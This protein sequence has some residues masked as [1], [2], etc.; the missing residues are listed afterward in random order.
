MAHI[1]V[2]LYN[3]YIKLKKKKKWSSKMNF[4][5]IIKDTDTY[6]YKKCQFH[7]VDFTSTVSIL[8][9]FEEAMTVNVC[10]TKRE[11]DWYLELADKIIFEVSGSG[12]IKGQELEIARAYKN[13]YQAYSRYLIKCFEQRCEN[14]LQGLYGFD[15]S[16]G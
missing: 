13:I 6:L 5:N 4:E 16:I 8:R 2:I 3:K 12:E 7:H 15:G 10:L 1:R 11:A 14:N 9:H